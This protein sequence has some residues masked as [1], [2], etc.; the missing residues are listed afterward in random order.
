MG[1]R[2]FTTVFLDSYTVAIGKLEHRNKWD[3]EVGWWQKDATLWLSGWH[4]NFGRL[5]PPAEQLLIP[6]GPFLAPV[7]TFLIT[8]A[9]FLIQFR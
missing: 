3:E 9:S 7:E 6:Y 8:I 5:A 2:T 1:L 4:H